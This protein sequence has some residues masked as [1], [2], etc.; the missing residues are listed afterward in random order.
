[1]NSINEHNRDLQQNGKFSEEE[2]KEN[3]LGRYSRE[4]IKHY[5]TLRASNTAS[6]A[7]YDNKGLLVAFLFAA[8]FIL[9]AVVLYFV[10][11]FDTLQTI[12]GGLFL[13]VMCVGFVV[14]LL[15]I[16]IV[17][18]RQFQASVDMM[19]NMGTPLTQNPLGQI[20][21]IEARV[22][23]RA[24]QA[25]INRQGKQSSQ[26]SYILQMDGIEFRISRA[27]YETIQPKRSYR[28]F[29]VQDQGAWDL[30][31]METLE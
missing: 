21:T 10:G 23:T 22:E 17:I 28:V 7:K 15:F 30:L 12:L 2:L 27:L 13:P 16:F 18:P 29:A 5:E 20:Q 25:G 14:I 26:I 8:G 24:S 19:K 9:F 1:M 6:A 31:S 4:Q 3:R 11:V